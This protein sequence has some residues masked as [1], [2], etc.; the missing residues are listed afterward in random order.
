M[1]VRTYDEV[2]LNLLKQPREKKD[3]KKKKSAINVMSMWSCLHAF[4]KVASAGK[5][6]G[7]L[8]S[9]SEMVSKTHILSMLFGL[10]LVLPCTGTCSVHNIN[11]DMMNVTKW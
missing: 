7:L 5:R 9:F 3:Q 10:L 8:F 1:S 6:Q 4:G 11:K 2:F